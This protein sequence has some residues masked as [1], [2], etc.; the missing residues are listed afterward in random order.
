[1]TTKIGNNFDAATV[2][3]ETPK[4]PSTLK[5]IAKATAN[6]M[7]GFFAGFISTAVA[8]K[9]AS[10]VTHAVIALTGADKRT[11]P[12]YKFFKVMKPVSLLAG[13]LAVGPS[14]NNQMVKSLNSPEGAEA[15]AL[16]LE[17]QPDE[18]ENIQTR[19]LILEKQIQAIIKKNWGLGLGFGSSSVIA[20]TIIFVGKQL[21]SI[22]KEK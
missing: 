17:L 3:F 2:S 15:E 12:C 8:V 22:A 7:L 10:V 21:L 20:P 1:M 13:L 14:I 5:C 11:H 18:V 6:L 9:G 16:E 4:V 19:F